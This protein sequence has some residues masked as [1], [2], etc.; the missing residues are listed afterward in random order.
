VTRRATLVAL[1]LAALLSSLVAVGGPVA[2]ADGDADPY[3]ADRVVIVGVPGLTWTDVAADRTPQLAEL[4]DRGAVGSLTVRAARSITCLLD[5]WATLGAGNRARY[6]GIEEPL[7][8]VPIPVPEENGTGEGPPDDAAP[9]PDGPGSLCDLQQLIADV[10]L[11]EPGP[12]VARIAEDEGTRRFGAEPGAL[13]TAVGCATAVGRPA[14]LAVAADG[15]ELTADQRL[16]GSVGGTERLLRTCPLTLVSVDDLLDTADLGPE[17]T[18]PP[19][20]SETV[21]DDRAAALADVDEAIGRIDRAAEGLPGDTLIMVAGISEVDDQRPRLHTVVA[22]GPG[23]DAGTWLTSASTGREPYV[24]LIDLAPTALRALGRDVPAS[25]NG[26]PMRAT[27]ERPDLA[28]T[29][30]RLDE[31]NVAARAH[32]KSTGILF[33]GLV[34][35]VTAV[36][37]LGILLLGTRAGRGRGGRR[38]RRLLRL[39]A[40]AVAA[41]PVATYLAGLVPWEAAGSP[42][43]VLLAAVLGADVLVVLL[44]VAGPWRRRR[45][46]PPLVVLAVTAATLVLD[47]LTGSN[48]ELNGLL[49]YDAIVAGRFVGYGNLTFGLLSVSVLLLT[50]ALATVVGRRVTPERRRTAV[51]ATVGVAGLVTIAVIGA[52]SLGR[53]FGGVLASLPGFA[54]LGMLLTRTRVTVVR[55]VAI[56]GAAVLAVGT[57]AVL[58]WLRPP[59]DRTH[60]GRFVAQLLSGEAATVVLRKAQA[61]VDIVLGSPLVWTLPAALVAAVWLLR[62]GGLLRGSGATDLLPG[63]LSAEGTAALRAGLLAVGV[64]LLLGAAVNDS[65]IAV[66]ATAAALLVPLLVWLV[67]APGT[68]A[69]DGSDEGNA[70]RSGPADDGDRVTVV[71]RGSTVWNA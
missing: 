32:Y 50:A 53:D 46:G 27:G 69:A 12:T 10:A 15:V 65:G 8:G 35:G 60:L 62:P 14:A 52:P 58:D 48:L 67:A 20:T 49:G 36:V 9:D 16:P 66:P 68:G 40:V 26:Q 55:I 63:G 6:P 39:G 56:L 57:V 64:S 45:L 33:W 61:N 18:E 2:A 22:V 21:R 11:S 19:L 23:F 38:S 25:M 24:Q 3:A 42:R 47:V 41:A 13:G 5:G 28:Q 70:P 37:A 1:L 54:L 59:E 31:L 44:A 34:A 30:D 43:L 51:A 7:P 4:A 71:S 17:A 29:V